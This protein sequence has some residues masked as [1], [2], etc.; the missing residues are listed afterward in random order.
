MEE[1]KQVQTETTTEKKEEKEFR[2]TFKTGMLSIY[3]ALG[4]LVLLV[5][6]SVITSFAG[7]SSVAHGIISLLIYP[8]AIASFVLPLLKN[9]RFDWET[10]FGMI[11]MLV[12]FFKM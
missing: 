4:A 11:A 12:V 3:L 2:F 5:L 8:L 1:E 10:I 7:Y 6:Y 9:K